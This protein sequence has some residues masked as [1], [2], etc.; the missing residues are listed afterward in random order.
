MHQDLIFYVVLVES[1]MIFAGSSPESGPVSDLVL[2]SVIGPN[3]RITEDHSSMR[4]NCHLGSS[5]L[6]SFTV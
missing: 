6:Q 4:Q 2:G 3:T 1:R 5:H